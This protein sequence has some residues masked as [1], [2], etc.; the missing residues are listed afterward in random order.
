MVIGRI[1]GKIYSD[2]FFLNVW[3]DIYAESF[4]SLNYEKKFFF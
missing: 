3:I 1:I 4:A 2:F